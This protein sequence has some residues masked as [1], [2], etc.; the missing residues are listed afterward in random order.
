MNE[1][2]EK[3]KTQRIYLDNEFFLS[4]DSF[5]G[6]V[7]EREV[8][9]TRVKLDENRKKTDQT[10]QYTDIESWYYPRLSQ[11][12]HKYLKLKSADANNV[13]E[14]IKAVEKVEKLIDQ[15]K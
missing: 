7:L 10:E 11:I 5:K 8:V 3:K 1:I 9:K 2:F 4:P 14:L 13:D 6:L 12:L 15:L